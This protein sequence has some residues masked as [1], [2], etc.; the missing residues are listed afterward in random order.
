MFGSTCTSENQP[1]RLSKYKPISSSNFTS[2]IISKILCLRLTNLLTTVVSIN[3]SGFVEIRSIS[4]NILLAQEIIN[5]IKKPNMGN[6]VVI[7]L[8]MTKAYDRVSWFFTCFVLRKFGFGELFI[9]MVQRTMANNWYTVTINGSKNVFFFI[10]PGV[11]S[12]VIL[13][14]LRYSS[15]V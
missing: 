9:D 12:K 4:E 7:N 6:N 5:H 13:Y 3:Q 2:K 15:W 8:Y 11:L 1:N 10:L 14:H